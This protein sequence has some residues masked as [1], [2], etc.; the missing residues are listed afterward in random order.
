MRSRAR[1][2][3][4]AG[5]IDRAL[6]KEFTEGDRVEANDASSF[7]NSVNEQQVGGIFLFLIHWFEFS[8][9][10][11]LLLKRDEFTIVVGYIVLQQWKYLI[12]II[13]D[14]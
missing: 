12:R 8:K 10:T 6:E 11:K 2:D 13:F 9:K 14:W 4:F 1:E 3:S 7:N 5:K